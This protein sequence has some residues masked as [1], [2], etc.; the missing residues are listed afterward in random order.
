[1]RFRRLNL[2]VLGLLALAGCR[3]PEVRAYRVPREK[4]PDPIPAAAAAGMANPHVNPHGAATAGALGWQAP[5]HWEEKPAGG[6]RRGSFRIPGPD[7]TDADLSI[8]AFP[9]AAGGMV[10]NLNRWRGQLGLAPSSPAEVNAALEHVDSRGGLHFDIID[11]VGTTNQEPTRILGAVAEHGGESWF[12][13]LMGPADLV[14]AE[15]AAF[16]RFLDT[17]ASSDSAR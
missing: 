8:I 1:M 11:Y 13:K 2:L 14:A 6:F 10:E 16:R 3:E 12:F 15:R 7:G 5:S 17:V 9:G 4:L